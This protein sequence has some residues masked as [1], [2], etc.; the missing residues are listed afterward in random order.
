MIDAAIF[1][2]SSGSP[3][4]L[5]NEG[6]WITR[7]GTVAGGYR[8]KLLGIVYAVAQHNVTGEITV[9]PAPTDLRQIA[10]SAIPN[11]LGVCIKAPRILEFEP[12]LVQSGIMQLPE[13][14]KMRALEP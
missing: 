5:F 6:A 2:G 10:V 8:I 12:V 14:Y 7:E 9:V 1:P 4:F 13:G 11:N 3:V